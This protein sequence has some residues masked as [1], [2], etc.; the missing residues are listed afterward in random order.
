MLVGICVSRTVY[1]GLKITYIARVHGKEGT[2]HLAQV[3]LTDVSLIA[4][5]QQWISIAGIN[6]VFISQP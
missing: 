3:W 2:S 4:F 6:Q 1:V 5:G